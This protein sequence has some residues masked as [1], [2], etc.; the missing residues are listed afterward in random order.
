MTTPAEPPRL[1]G[2]SVAVNAGG[3]RL[4][5]ELEIDIAV[6]TVTA[7]IGPNGAGKSTLLRALGRLMPLA[8]GRVLLDGVDIHTLRPRQVGRALGVLSQAS[9]APTG[10][11]V[12]QLI[13]QGRYPH[14]G[15]LG[16]L[17]KSDSEAIGRALADTALEH[18][19]SRTVASLS[20]GERQ[21]A[22]LALALVQEPDTLLLD[23]PTTFLDIAHQLETLEL[24][25][26]LN[27]SRRI[28]IAMVLHDL[29]QAARF[30]DRIIVLD[31][32]RLVADGTPASIIS[33]ELIADVFRVES[34]V[35]IDPETGRPTATFH[36][37]L[38][39]VRQ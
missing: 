8:S 2:R 3:T 28:T 7:I 1:A 32:G 15:L 20:G 39:A 9:E 11:T 34:T 19:A 30:A 33:T 37:S 6:G 18:L 24:I 25:S 22:W 29:N 35:R 4:I 36:R 14:T 12:R 31:K 26:E 21:R 13:E 23:E 38:G 5:G 27:R 10:F 16:M 17:R